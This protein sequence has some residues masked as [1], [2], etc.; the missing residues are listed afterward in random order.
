MFDK[1]FSL[2]TRKQH[3]HYL[4]NLIQQFLY[5]I[6][7]NDII[8]GFILVIIHW[9]I[10]CIPLLYLLLGKVNGLYYL[11][12][13]LLYIVVFFHFYFKGC[14]LVRIERHLWRETQKQRQV[15]SQQQ[16]KAQ[17]QVKQWWGPWIFIFT[18]LE[19]IGIP[20]TSKLAN[21][22]INCGIILITIIIICK[23][24]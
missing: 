20:M 22:I 16:V 12:I 11:L 18:P 8:S 19:Y 17:Q 7:G 10:T 3:T 5:R 14:L 6:T 13:F 1:I 2:E 15:K 21:K 9:L 23:I 24:K 4:T